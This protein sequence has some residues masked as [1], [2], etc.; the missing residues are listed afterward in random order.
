MF[1]VTFVF[2]RLNERCIQGDVAPQIQIH[3]IVWVCMKMVKVFSLSVF[4]KGQNS[5]TISLELNL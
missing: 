4:L 2:S 1:S 3:I 5:L